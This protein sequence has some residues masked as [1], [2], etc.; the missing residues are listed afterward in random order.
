MKEKKI[1]IFDG[2]KSQF[3]EFLTEKKIT[4]YESLTEKKSQFYDLFRCILGDLGGSEYC[5]LLSLFK[6]ETNF[7]D[8]LNF[9]FS[10]FIIVFPIYFSSSV[11]IQKLELT[12]L[13]IF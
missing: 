5:Y 10:L 1:T 4:I 3:D 9:H 8:F 12:F 7:H 6:M 11:K 13:T 2:K